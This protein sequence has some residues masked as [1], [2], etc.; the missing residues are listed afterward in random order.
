MSVKT[1]QCCQCGSPLP[2]P[3]NADA[4]FNQCQHCSAS[5][6]IQDLERGSITRL[7]AALTE[8]QEVTADHTCL[9][10]QMR[11]EHDLERLDWEWHKQWKKRAG[12]NEVQSKLGAGI[13]TLMLVCISIDSLFA[14]WSARKLE[15]NNVFG[16]AV[17]GCLSCFIWW[18][19]KRYCT[20]RQEYLSRRQDIQYQLA[21]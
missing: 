20:A 12:C 13:A 21:D 11:L 2:L 17:L 19:T 7:R 6:E 8:V 1:V 18:D 10:E 5:L 4:K 9:I 3:E 14:A 15:I 16:V